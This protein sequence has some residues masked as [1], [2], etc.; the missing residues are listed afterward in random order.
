[1]PDTTS[2]PGTIRVPSSAHRVSAPPRRKL[3]PAD[4][5]AMVLFGA[6]GDLTKRLVVPALYNL[7]RTGVLPDNFALIGVDHGDRDTEAWRG[8]LLDMLKSFVG[9]ASSEFNVDGIDQAAWD[10]LAKTMT[11]LR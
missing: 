10:R 2:N 9:N 3:K 4:P 5:C 6:G 7:A 8:Q 11:Y 1:M